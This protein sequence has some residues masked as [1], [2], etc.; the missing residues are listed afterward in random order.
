[1]CLLLCVRVCVCVCVSSRVS[2]RTTVR[3]WRWVGGFGTKTNLSL[4]TT[5]WRWRHMMVVVVGRRHPSIPP[6]IVSFPLSACRW[7]DV[8]ARGVYPHHQQLLL[9]Y[10]E[11]HVTN[12]RK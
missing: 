12:H 5:S 2:F 6:F 1:M 8:R 10:L 11:T 4:P 9:F 7:T 3:W